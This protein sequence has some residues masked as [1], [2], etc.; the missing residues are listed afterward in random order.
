M[1]PLDEYRRKRDPRRT[2]EPMPAGPAPGKQPPGAQATGKKAA[3]KQANDGQAEGNSFVVQEHHAS[4]L[5]WDFR[6]ERDGVLVSWAV[7]KGIPPDPKRNHLAVHVEDHPLEY[8]TFEGDIGHG[9]YGAG[10]VIIWDHG[11]YETEK[12]SDR[13]VKVVLHGRRTQGRFVLFQTGGKNWMMHRMDA[14]QRA[15]WEPLPEHLRPMLA[16][17]GELPPDD[18]HWA[19]EMK[20]DGVRALV[21]VEGGRITITSRNDRDVTVSYPELRA[22][23]EQL[24]STQVLLDGEIVSFDDNGR[25]SFGRLQ[26]RM[27]VASASSARRLA[28][29]DPAVYLI[30][31][32][33]HLDGRSLLKLPYTQRRELLDGL[34]LAG[35]S[36]QT[37]PAFEGDGAQ[38][39]QASRQQGLEGV[40]AK[41]LTSRYT[42]A[43]RAGDWV[44]VKN[45]RT[46]EVVVG[47][48]SPGKGRR[49]GTIGALLLGLPGADG[50]R[51]IGQVGTGF[52]DDMLADLS[53]RLHRI[54]RKTSPF[55]PDVP[56]T[57]ARDAQ[58]ASPRLVG[59]VA[60][61]EW[62]ADG[63]L[64]HPSWRGLRPDK[65]PSEVV[66]ES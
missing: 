19:Y 40:V 45:I 8:A 32:L 57:D 18:Q 22:L 30:F 37:P 24:G 47:G 61:S 64:R 59:E 49:S 7:P 13:E 56:R 58:W 53:A 14:P 3:G 16:T 33:L 11:T 2:P 26:Q 54:A 43:R 39:V 50:L 55:D 20:W 34:D 29:S 63:R 23:G 6:L 62:T 17:L 5:H 1:A 66:Q 41:R 27:H 48:W 36:W 21:S 4:S 46:Q 60:F 9:E 31:D 28:E 12:W 10:K 44:K 42:P 15:G 35:E 25:P 51:Y 65:S 52:T 38:A